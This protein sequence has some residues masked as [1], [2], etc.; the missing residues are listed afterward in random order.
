[1]II[2][3]RRAYEKPGPEDGLRILV[4]RL[5]PRGISKKDAKLD[6]WLKDVAPSNELRKWYGHDPA[7]WA[8][9]KKRYFEELD[10]EKAAVDELRNTVKGKDV[11]F[12]YSSKEEKYNSAAALREYLGR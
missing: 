6:L 8:E 5:W 11:T 1:M 10:R 4:E 2:K 9:F 12:V 3:L 7:K